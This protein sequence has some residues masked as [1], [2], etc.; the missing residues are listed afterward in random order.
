MAMNTKPRVT[1]GRIQPYCR[2]SDLGVLR[3]TPRGRTKQTQDSGRRLPLNFPYF[4]VHAHLLPT[5]KVMF[6]SQEPAR[7]IPSTILGSRGIQAT[8]ALP[9]PRYDVFAPANRSWPTEG[10]SLRVATTPQLQ[11]LLDLRTQVSTTQQQYLD[12]Q[13]RPRPYSGGWQRARHERRALVPYRTV[14]A[15]GDV[16]VISGFDPSS[17]FNTLPQVFQVGSGWRDLTPRGSA[18]ILT[19][20]CSSRQTARSSRRHRRRR[21]VIL[22]RPGPVH[23]AWSGTGSPSTK[24]PA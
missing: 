14:L 15:N 9:L 6:W 23:G 18:W 12:S 19:H 7:P 1:T 21:P 5:G 3:R 11:I 16:L 2:R 20:R 17:D 4:P 22:I 24:S 13:T 10:C 8:L